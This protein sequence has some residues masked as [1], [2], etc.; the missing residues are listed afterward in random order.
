MC[1]AESEEL[2]VTLT[3]ESR[4]PKGQSCFRAAGCGSAASGAMCG[5]LRSQYGV[6]VDDGVLDGLVNCPG[7]SFR[8]TR[9]AHS[10]FLASCDDK[11]EARRV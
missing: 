1:D 7:V 9:E 8:L 2:R 6:W 10:R 3:S 4:A 11:F 5:P